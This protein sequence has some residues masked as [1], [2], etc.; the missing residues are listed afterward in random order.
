MLLSAIQAYIVG[1]LRI[2]SCRLGGLTLHWNSEQLLILGGLYTAI[3][4]CCFYRKLIYELRVSF[5][6]LTCMVGKKW[7][8]S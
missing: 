4:W 2:V 5:W 6:F 7:L 8:L 3:A 1:I